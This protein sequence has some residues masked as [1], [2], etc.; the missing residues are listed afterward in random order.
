MPVT[1]VRS[2][3]S[4]GSLIF[5]TAAGTELMTISD[6]G[7]N[8]PTFTIDD[9]VLD[10]GAVIDLNG[11]A[12]SLVLDADADTHIGASTD[13]QVD[14]TISGAIDFQF[15]ANTLTA[16]SG[17]SI[18]TNTITETTSGSGVTIDGLLIKDSAPDLNG[19][20]MILD[21]DADTTMAADTDDQIDI[22]IAGADDFQFTAN[23]FTAL[24]G[25]SIATDTIAETTAANGVAV[26]T[27]LLHDGRV[28]QAQP[29]PTAETGVATI[30]IADILTR[31]VTITH[32]TGSDIALTLDD[33]TSM[34]AGD[35]AALGT[36]I[37][38]EWS[39]LNLSAAAA[40]TATLTAAAG[41]TIVGN[42]IVQSA[43][44]STGGIY[45][46]SARFL[47]RRTAANTWITYRIA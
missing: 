23:T 35:P 41:H 40:D 26:D 31:I 24:S 20:E 14:I 44:S 11:I 3:W 16:L 36:D 12:A 2:R 38:I 32:A 4:S 10:A 28:W 37:G 34:D 18:A 45:G 19:V 27:V 8:I 13:D 7:V 30:T 17:S 47:S 29:A 43:H 22:K 46:N 39:I 15:T 5:E 9:F 6:T 1:K 33:G 42:P 21:A 25:S